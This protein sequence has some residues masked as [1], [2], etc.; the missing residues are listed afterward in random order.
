MFL[1]R[2]LSAPINH[3]RFFNTSSLSY[4]KRVSAISKSE[5]DPCSINERVRMLIKLCNL[6]AAAEHARLVVLSRDK[7]KVTAETCAAVLQA[8]CDDRRYSDAYDLFHYFTA[9]SNSDLVSKSCR[10]PIVTGFCDQG[11]LDEALELYQ[12]L[13]K[14]PS[15]RA[16]L[17]L[18]Q[19][20][21]DAGRIDEAMR[22]FY[23]VAR[24]VYDIFIRGLLDVGN[25]ER[26][27]ELYDDLKLCEDLDCVVEVSAT[28]MEHWFKQG[29]DEKAM[30]CYLSFKE[31]HRQMRASTGNRLLK[32]LLKY[33][34]KTEAWS[35]FNQM[36]ATR[37]DSESCNIMVNECFKIGKVGEAIQIFDKL[38][39][40]SED[41]QLC[42]R[43]MITRL[44]EQ[45]MLSEA[46]RF[47][48]QMC[49]QNHLVP[50]VPTYRTM[51]DAYVK[52]D[53]VSDAR[54]NLNQTLDACLTFTSKMV[55][56]YR[57][58]HC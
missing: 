12:H 26:A 33:G 43:N 41:P 52:A 3:R 28:F 17:A 14:G 10:I 7:P 9:N 50:D 58:S 39:G 29:M 55:G 2:F 15:S 6:D 35:L 13:R 54:K 27:N 18:A 47:F 30:E 46:E 42:Y 31:E 36:K 23:C 49:S 57:L 48:A 25:V 32:V 22:L 8:L 38:V 24:P 1:S 34:K 51:T 37:F 40:T 20:L 5:L 53:R 21:V 16:H 44:C 45:G 4:L 56:L 11:K 19:G